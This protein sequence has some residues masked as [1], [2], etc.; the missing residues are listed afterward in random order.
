MKKTIA[1]TL[2]A[3]A[4]SAHADDAIISKKLHDFGLKSV[5]IGDSPIPGLRSGITEQ[6]IC[7]AHEDG[8]YYPQGDQSE[9][10]HKWPSVLSTP[11]PPAEPAD[12]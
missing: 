4:A 10:G 8:K 9:L 6:G 3:L 7:Y 1:L 5:E 12:P 11:L 2:L